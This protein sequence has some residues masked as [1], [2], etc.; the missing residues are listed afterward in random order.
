MNPPRLVDST[1]D[2]VVQRS[3]GLA[4][5]CRPT[6][7]TATRRFRTQYG[8]G[9]TSI[10]DVALVNVQTVF[11]QQLPEFF[12]KPLLSVVI[13]TILSGLPRF[14]VHSPRVADKGR[15]PWSVLLNAFSVGFVG[16]GTAV[17]GDF[18]ATRKTPVR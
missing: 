14:M 4:D 1:P 17:E 13:C 16:S 15:Q 11:R 3:P 18:L 12:V 6:L 2:G 8:F 9:R 5:P 10:P 7:G